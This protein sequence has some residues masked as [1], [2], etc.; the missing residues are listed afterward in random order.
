MTAVC[1]RTEDSELNSIFCLGNGRSAASLMLLVWRLNCIPHSKI[2]TAVILCLQWDVG[3]GFLFLSAPVVPSL[4]EPQRE[5]VLMSLLVPVGEL[6]LFFRWRWACGGVR[7]V[8]SCGGPASV[9][10]RPC[11]PGFWN[12]AFPSILSSPPVAAK[13]PSHLWLVLGGR[14]FL[15][16]LLVAAD[17]CLASVQNPGP[18]VSFLPGTHRVSASA[19]SLEALGHLGS[20][21]RR[22]YCPF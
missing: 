20:G 9:S 13:F 16:H 14:G 10:D 2:V 17:L 21:D 19:P 6:L 1:R 3:C 8:L 15:V 22:V 12:Q 18:R 4:P 7:R 11:V 5:T